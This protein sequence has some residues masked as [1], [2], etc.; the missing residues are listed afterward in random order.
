MDDERRRT[1]GGRWCWERRR[2]KMMRVRRLDKL[3][4][5]KI[6]SNNNNNNNNNNN[7]KEEILYIQKQ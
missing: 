3:N 5:Q 2:V 4:K 7:K 6:I 1:R